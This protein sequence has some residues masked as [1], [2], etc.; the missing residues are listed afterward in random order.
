MKKRIKDSEQEYRSRVLESKGEKAFN[1]TM[2][3]LGVVLSL[4]VLYPIYYTFIASISRPFY[5]DTGAVMF[6]PVEVTLGSYIRAFE[7]EFLGSSYLNSIYYTVFGVIVNMA[8]TTTMAYALSKHRLLWRKFWVLF[9]VFTMWFNAGLIPTYM[10]FKDLDLLDTRTAI[11]LGFAVNTYNLIIMKSF[12]EQL[13]NELEEAAFMDGASNFRIFWQ[14]FLPLSKPALATVGMFY[15]VSRW[16]SYFWAMTLISDD[17]KIPLQVLLRKLIIDQIATENEA[18]LITAE[19]LFSPTTLQY[20]III[21]AMVPM[22]IAYPFVQKYF[23]SGVTL[24]A[25]KG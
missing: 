12:F 3:I 7:T 22:L 14:I 24:G 17:L 23:K 11:V 18:G 9:T 19:S 15:G 1:I 8:F 6:W 25:V 13:P 21:I 4:F 16:N 5:V 10:N 2:N 20:A